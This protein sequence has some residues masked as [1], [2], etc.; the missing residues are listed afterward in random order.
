MKTK[1]FGSTGTL[2][3]TLL[4]AALMLLLTSCAGGT[5]YGAANINS[6]PEGAEII[7][8]KDNTNLVWGIL[9]L[10]QQTGGERWSAALTVELP[11]KPLT[12]HQNFPNPFNPS[13]TI[14]F[15]LP[16]GG[17]LACTGKQAQFRVGVQGLD[18]VVVGLDLEEGEKHIPVKGVFADGTE[19]YEYYSGSYVSVKK[20]S[21]SL[22]S[23]YN[24]VLLVR[25]NS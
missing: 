23:E 11:P 16:N 9:V 2:A 24:I 12:L 17:R 25:T 18:Q 19:L 15:F 1:R 10:Y 13:T 3:S 4:A 6:T 5:R 20:G 22:Y 14:A 21:V 7:N 8:L